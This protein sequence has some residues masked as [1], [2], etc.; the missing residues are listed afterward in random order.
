MIRIYFSFI[1]TILLAFISQSSMAQCH[2]TAIAFPKEVCPGEQVTL[3]ASGGC[4]YL[5]TNIN[6][7]TINVDVSFNNP[8][9]PGASGSHLWM[10]SR[11]QN[12]KVLTTDYVNVFLE[13]G[14]IEWYMRYG[15]Q[16]DTGTC[17]A[18]NAPNE[19]VALQYSV[20]SGATWHNFPGPNEEPVGN[21][22]SNPPFTTTTPGTGSY[23][24]PH[25]SPQE[26]QN[27]ELY[28]WNKYENKIPD[29]AVS[30]HTKFRFVQL[31][32]DG[33]GNDTWGIDEPN[34]KLPY[35]SLNVEWEHGPNMLNPPS[36][37]LPKPGTEPYDTCFI[38]TISDT[39]NSASD[40]VCVTVNPIPKP[41]IGYEWIESD[42]ILFTD[43]SF[44]ANAGWANAD[45]QWYFDS[46]ATPSSSTDK[47]VLVTYNSPG[48]YT[49]TLE[50]TYKGCKGR[51]TLDAIITSKE[52][53]QQQTNDFN[54]YP[55]PSNGKFIVEIPGKVD[56][57]IN[58]TIYD[59]KGKLI[60]TKNKIRKDQIRFDLSQQSPG[61]YLIRLQYDEK[62]KTRQIVI[63]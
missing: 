22:D 39:I 20:D 9:G 34:I 30:P 59:T 19:G 38:V 43:N 56:S 7:Q 42:E 15:R 5:N 46:A 2:I 14:V 35:G 4:S 26:Q 31:F 53:K 10:G 40:T 58:M 21:M 62:I 1:F 61:I 16:Q 44:T 17:N 55:S 12:P 27:S 54:V 60:A 49:T 28:Y 8:C 51:S 52:E 25:F 11:N 57:E 32:H 18:P 33:Q 37:T 41:V 29:G 36:I 63:E 47:S 50:I 48:T 6:W 23:W 45:T 3:S 13:G 24:Q